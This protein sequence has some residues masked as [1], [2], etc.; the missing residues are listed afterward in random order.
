MERNRFVR[1]TVFNNGLPSTRF[2]MPTPEEL[3]RVRQMRIKE[4]LIADPTLGG[5]ITEPVWTG[6][7]DSPSTDRSITE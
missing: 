6:D 3:E 4:A 5:K 7:I 2:A 1:K